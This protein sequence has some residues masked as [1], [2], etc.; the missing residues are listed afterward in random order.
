MFEPCKT[1]LKLLTASEFYYVLS[2]FSQASA[3]DDVVCE[4]F[5]NDFVNCPE[6]IIQRQK[7]LFIKFKFGISASISSRKCSPEVAANDSLDLRIR[8]V[9][10][11]RPKQTLLTGQDYP[12]LRSHIGRTSPLNFDESKSFV[13]FDSTTERSLVSENLSILS[14]APRI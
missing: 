6:I 13:M 14:Q 8:R 10:F 1:P 12:N 3:N 5:N 9:P 7:K 11:S 4:T 2:Y